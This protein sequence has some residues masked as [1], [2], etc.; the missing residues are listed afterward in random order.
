MKRQEALRAVGWMLAL[1]LPAAAADVP[2]RFACPPSLASG[3][4]LAPP[5]W[6]AIEPSGPAPLERAG[7][8]AGPPAE[9]A[10]LV[11]DDTASRP[12]NS[13]D[14][15]RF[16]SEGRHDIWLA[17]FYRG[18]AAFLAMRMQPRP[19]QCRIGHATL[20]SGVRIRVLGIDCE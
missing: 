18:H 15:W 19:R 10:A 9:G 3:H 11:P 20:P 16:P 17:C 5:G 1:A 4:A 7:F 12:G 6:V 13:T 14:A 8:Y 2:V